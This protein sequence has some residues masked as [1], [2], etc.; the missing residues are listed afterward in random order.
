M[1]MD[2][3]CVAAVVS[4]GRVYWVHA[5]THSASDRRVTSAVE[6]RLRLVDDCTVAA[7]SVPETGILW[8]RTEKVGSGF[9]AWGGT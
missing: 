4:P 3:R 1:L 6:A 8:P 9:I 7:G 5:G 2:Y